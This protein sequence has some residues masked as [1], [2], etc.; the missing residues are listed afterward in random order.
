MTTHRYAASAVWSG[1]TG[2]GYD[3]YSRAHEVVLGGAGE[4]K[5]SAD[6]AFRGD[7]AL[8]NPEQLVLA[9]ASSCQLL[10]FL[11]I[12]ARSRVDVVSYTDE[13]EA[14]MPDD[15]R[16]VRLTRITLRPR[17]TVRGADQAKIEKLVRKAHDQCYIANSL[18]TEI[19]VEPVI[20]VLP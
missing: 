2:V 20:E 6:P 14:E 8:V 4:L 13:A 11:A 7:P 16:P 15:D 5:V 1:S 18:T 12:A 19:V 17:I 9:A 10:S 3:D